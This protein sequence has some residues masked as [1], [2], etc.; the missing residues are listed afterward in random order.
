MDERTQ[1]FL[2]DLASYEQ[3]TDTI[4][5]CYVDLDAPSVP[6]VRLHEWAGMRMLPCPGWMLRKEPDDV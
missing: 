1:K 3:D 4:V 5:G 6:P 2:K